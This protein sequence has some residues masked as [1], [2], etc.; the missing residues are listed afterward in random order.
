MNYYCRFYIDEVPIREII[1]SEEMGADYP[2]KPMA[3]YATIWD[4]SNWA[5]SGGKYKVNYKY[6][7]FVTEMK[8]LVLKGCSVDPI[9]EVS[10][11]EL[12]SDQHADLE[13]QDYAAVTPLRRLAMRRFRQRYMYYS[14]CYD[15]LRYSVPPPECVIIP[16]EKQRFKETGRLRFGGSHRR[17]SRARR[18]RTS[19]PVD[20]S[21]QGD[22]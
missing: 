5:T 17:H 15:T 14:Y 3:L 6:A 10:A 16:A 21:D 13:E 4:A 2:A 9:Q 7:P 20:E 22:M 11:R 19:T 1:R 18:S 8:D 12:C